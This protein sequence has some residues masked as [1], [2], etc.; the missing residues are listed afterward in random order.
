MENFENYQIDPPQVDDGEKELID[1]KELILTDDISIEN[2]DEIETLEVPDDSD[3]PIGIQRKGQIVYFMDSTKFWNRWGGDQG[4]KRKDLWIDYDP[5]AIQNMT[6]RNGNLRGN[7]LSLGTTYKVGRTAYDKFGGKGFSKAGWLVFGPYPKF[8]PSHGVR[9]LP[10]LGNFRHK[11][12]YTFFVDSIG[13]AP[14]DPILICDCSHSKGKHII[15]NK[16]ITPQFIRNHQVA[17]GKQPRPVTIMTVDIEFGG[18]RTT[19]KDFET[20]IYWTGKGK[21][22][23]GHIRVYQW[24]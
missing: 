12:K 20:R 9:T 18:S 4:W 3:S 7:L 22:I 19:Y 2:E 16:K 5:R 8:S 11:A 10:S 23:F 24:S 21:V 15:A 13:V 17:Q 1:L 6:G 14:N